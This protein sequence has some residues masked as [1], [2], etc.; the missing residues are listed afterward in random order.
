MKLWV[1]IALASLLT[2]N[3]SACNREQ[4]AKSGATGSSGQTPPGGA[5]GQGSEGSTDAS[6]A[7][8]RPASK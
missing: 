8:K 5:T 6:K 1:A 4:G 3:L 7:P 2:F